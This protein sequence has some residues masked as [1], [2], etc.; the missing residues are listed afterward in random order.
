MLTVS[1]KRLSP[2]AILPIKGSVEAACFDL[3]VDNVIAEREGWTVHTGLAIALPPGY[4]MF[5]FARSGLA[6]KFGLT[7]R[8]GTGVIDSDY[9]GELLLK[10]NSGNS[11]MSLL[12]QHA[13]TQGSR[14]AQATILQIPEVVLEEV[15]ELPDSVRGTGGFGS[16]GT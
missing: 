3:H 2:T 5:I 9:R 10:F 12:I 1:V 11:G 14:I 15:S 4:G 6:T 13:L 7:L 16:T 8:N